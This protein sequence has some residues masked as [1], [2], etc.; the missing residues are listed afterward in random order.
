MSL[1]SS[2]CNFLVATCSSPVAVAGKGA[3]AAIQKSLF[4]L[5]LC[6]PNSRTSKWYEK[7][8]QVSKYKCVRNSSEVAPASYSRAYSSTFEWNLQ[9]EICWLVP[10]QTLWTMD[11]QLCSFNSVWCFWKAPVV[12]RAVQ[13]WHGQLV[14]GNWLYHP[15]PLQMLQMCEELRVKGTLSTFSKNSEVSFKKGE[16]SNPSQSSLFEQNGQSFP[17]GSSICHSVL[18]QC[19]FC[20]SVRKMMQ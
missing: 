18:V 1:Q 17:R 7:S 15:G 14:L 10:V 6:Y 8:K 9:I 3:V 12:L 4:P 19:S 20:R 2:P 5:P 16:F 11:W 13:F